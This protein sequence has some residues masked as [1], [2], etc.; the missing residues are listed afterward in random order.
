LIG[1]VIL[2]M[3]PTATS[4]STSMTSPV[5]ESSTIGGLPE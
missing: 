3:P 5:A 1:T 2:G 4:S